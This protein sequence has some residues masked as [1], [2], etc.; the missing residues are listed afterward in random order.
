MYWDTE[1]VCD[2]TKHNLSCHKQS[3]LSNIGFKIKPSQLVL[4]TLLPTLEI[5]LVEV[6]NFSVSGHFFY[7]CCCLLTFSDDLMCKSPQHQ[8]T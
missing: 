4:I 5:K 2:D 7:I 3:I 1:F 6:F 8:S